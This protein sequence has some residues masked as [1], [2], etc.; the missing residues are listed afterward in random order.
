VD[1][2]DFD[3]YV[4]EHNV[5]PEDYGEAFADWLAQETGEPIIGGPAGEAPSVVALPDESD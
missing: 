4:A 3:R 5:P 2:S 1:F